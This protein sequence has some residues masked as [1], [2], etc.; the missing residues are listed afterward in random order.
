MTSIIEWIEE[1]IKNEYIHYFEYGKFSHFDEIGR[2]SFGKVI[3]AN[4][5]NRG[6]VA[7]KIFF[8]DN[9]KEKLNEEFVKELKLLCEIDYHSNI[10]RFLGVT[11]DS[12]SYTL[13]GCFIMGNFKEEPIKDT[14]LKYQQLYQKCWD[15]EPKSRPDIKEVYKILNEAPNRYL[16]YSRKRTD[17]NMPMTKI[18]SHISSMWYKEPAM[19]TLK[20]RIIH[21]RR[22]RRSI[23]KIHG[24]FIVIFSL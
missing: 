11:N 1:K 16:I 17:D 8:N 12:M 4:L 9:S 20:N 21:K 13:F 19:M 6:L 3:K 22:I 5:A 18:S 14:P 10:N 7:L 2:G 15:D 23:N 24:I